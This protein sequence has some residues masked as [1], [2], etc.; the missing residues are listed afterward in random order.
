MRMVECY[1]LFSEE[2]A[3]VNEVSVEYYLSGED[4]SQ[5]TGCPLVSF[6]TGCVVSEDVVVLDFPMVRDGFVP[7]IDFVDET[8]CLDKE[9]VD[10]AT[11][12]GI[13]GSG[14]REWGG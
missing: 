12:Y 6:D 4:S 13:G 9:S 2:I 8:V 7:D 10:Y 1:F 11:C 3:E 5:E 14:R